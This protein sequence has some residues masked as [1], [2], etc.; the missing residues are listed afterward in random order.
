MRMSVNFWVSCLS[1]AAL[2]A[3]GGGGSSTSSVGGGDIAAPSIAGSLGPI[4]PVQVA[5]FG[6]D[7]SNSGGFGAADA[8]ADGTAGE[9]GP[10]NNG[11]VIITD[12]SNP[13]KTVRVK[14]DA[15]GYYFA[16]ITGFTAPL[17][18]KVVS[19]NGKVYNSVRDDAVAA[20]VVATINITALTDKVSSLVAGTASVS[21]L[22][23]ADITSAKVTAAKAEV[24][25]T[26][27]TALTAAGVPNPSAF[28][29]IKTPFKADGTGYDKV[30]DQVRHETNA[31]GG[32]DLYPKTVNYV[33]DGSVS[34]LPLSPSLTLVLSSGKELNFDRLESLR[35]R[36]V[37]CFAQ[38]EAARNFG[39][40]G[41]ACSG[42]VHPNFKS[43]GRDFEEVVVQASGR[44]DGNRIL[45]AADVMTGAQF[46]APE[47]LLQEKS[48]ATV[49][50]FDKSIVRISWYQPANQSYR[51]ADF[52]M[53]RFDGF[54]NSAAQ[55]SLITNKDAS[56]SDWWFYGGQSNY[57]YG[58]SSRLYRYTNLNP[59]T[60][61][62]AN[63]ISAAISN[64]ESALGLYV[65]TQKFNTATRAWEDSGIAYAKVTG[66]GLPI[67]GIVVSRISSSTSTGTCINPLDSAYSVSNA[68]IPTEA[69]YLGYYSSTGVL[70]GTVGTNVVPS[71][72]QSYT[73]SV[74][75]YSIPGPSL[76]VGVSRTVVAS[77]I[78]APVTA[79]YNFD[80]SVPGLGTLTQS[81]V[82][83][84]NTF[85]N[86]PFTFPQTSSSVG[87]TSFTV[88]VTYTSGAQTNS[89]TTSAFDVFTN[90]VTLPIG[91]MRTVGFNQFNF[92]AAPVTYTMAVTVPGQP[93][94]SQSTL[95]PVGT[96]SFVGVAFPQTAASVGVN[97]FSARISYTSLTQ[98]FTFTYAAF[99]G[100]T[101]N[102]YS[103]ERSY[104][105]TGAS[106]PY[107]TTTSAYGSNRNTLP[108]DY[109]A[110]K[111]W[112][113]YKFEM[114][115]A[116]GVLLSTEFDRISNQVR[117]P[118]ALRTMPLHDLSPS[119]NT[120]L[121]P[122]KA[123]ATNVDVA[124][125]N[126]PGLPAPRSVGAF[127]FIFD[128]VTNPVSSRFEHGQR[129][130][131]QELS[132]SGPALVTF[133][134]SSASNFAG[135][136]LPAS[137][138]YAMERLEAARAVK[139][140]GGTASNTDRSVF[141]TSFINRM[142]ITQTSE[143]FNY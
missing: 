138:T 56:S 129:L 91:S 67:T 61:T 92:Q 143:W 42:L 13:A 101:T 32:T 60:N 49:A 122:A 44:R 58:V 72:Q 107:G 127:S 19:Q 40:T 28:D 82:V 136:R 25:A 69:T 114:Y 119:H 55:K 121:A 84:P 86:V 41:N 22:A 89:Y 45:E 52:A 71:T 9:G 142:R 20:G 105:D 80:L 90:P 21:A 117:P 139:V 140:N 51:Q 57:G 26:F 75:D 59:A 16:K 27:I 30:L 65:G 70:P 77:G 102:R 50:D 23:P 31:A 4:D 62:S 128:S 116:A 35:Q 34:T 15:T 38:A 99:T 46:D 5:S 113:V 3:C 93:T 24:L 88:L 66:P 29:P 81:A 118:Q 137:N 1:L 120:L 111:P 125:I 141:L 2:A 6:V 115:S 123:A 96:S 109:A 103:L 53:R 47:I 132:T 17:L 63:T 83:P 130:K 100:S 68:P 112:S 124:W 39:G 108:V 134:A 54:S 43:A 74:F 73:S 76:P 36:M 104:Q 98:T 87:L 18:V 95:I 48:T 94:V 64:D 8:G 106:F 12:A 126:N 110:L 33:A 14:T 7:G 37:A 133:T 10:I 97:S 79:T 11:T 78:S 85:G 131:R 135:C